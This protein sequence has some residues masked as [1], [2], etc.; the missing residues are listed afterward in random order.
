M[1]IVI[2]GGSGLVGSKL[3]ERLTAEG[4]E[5]VSASPNSGVDT[6]T[7]EGVAEVLEGTQVVIDVS[8]SPSFADADVLAFFETSTRNLLAAEAAAGVGHHVAVSI[9]GAPTLPDSGYL[10]AKVAQERLIEAG[11]VPFSIVRST[12][13]FEF[14]TSIADAA[15]DGDTVHMPPVRF[16]PIAA[17][18]VA[19]AV[20]AV[21]TG[22]PVNGLV[23]IAGPQE[24]GFDAFI[25]AALAAR[26]DARIV[27]ADPHAKYF[28]TELA[29]GSLVPEDVTAARLGTTTFEEWQGRQAAAAAK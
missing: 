3:M 17:D 21:A 7:G 27:V 23:E 18:D 22:A 11:D 4:H 26:G 16:R 15:T 28:G 24:F 1:K 13:F 12:Q 14:G 10:R 5:A 9:V 19:D 29:D 20:A 8:N 2:I 25:A 6:L